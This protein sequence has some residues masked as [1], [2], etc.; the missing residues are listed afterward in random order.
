M[1]LLACE[2]RFQ[3]RPEIL[4]WIYMLLMLWVLEFRTKDGRRYL[5]LLPL[6]QVMWTN[7]EGLFG[8]GLGLMAF[9]VISDFFHSSKVDKAL[10][11]YASLAAASC[12]INPY[13][14][15]G[16]LLPFTY[17]ATL[18]A[19]SPFKQAIA[20]FQ[21]PWAMGN[22]FTTPALA[23]LSYKVYFFLLLFLLLA[24]FRKRQV[25]EFLVAGAFAY[26]SA[27]ALRNIPLFMLATLP[28]A[29]AAWRDLQWAWLQTFQARVLSRP[30]AAWVLVVAIV[31]LASRT[32][33]S[34]GY[35][36]EG[37]QDRFGLGLD[38]DT[39]PVRAGTFLVANNLEGRILNQMNTGGWLDWV[40]P[41]QVFIDGRTEVMGEDLFVESTA[42]LAP[43]GL[44]R[45]AAAYHPDILFFN[46]FAARQWL[47]DLDKM[48]DWRLVY[49]DEVVC[50]FLRKDYAPQV[51][52]L[53]PQRLLTERGIFTG[54]RER[55]G[56]PARASA[57]GMA[58]SGRGLLQ[59]RCSPERSADDGA[60]FSVPRRAAAVG[61]I[62]PG[63][64]QTEPRAFLR[65][66]LQR[67]PDVLPVS[68]ERKSQGLHGACARC[69]PWQC[70]CDEDPGKPLY[71]LSGNFCSTHPRIA[72]KTCLLFFSIIMK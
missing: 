64:H 35:I 41:G 24:T 53:D 50:V 15:R 67:G 40:R 56:S 38:T 21:S 14:F 11:L 17:L 45:I 71:A 9:S 16:V 42:S 18:D 48:A 62:L 61:G 60:L 25:R 36:S 20:E 2:V 31:A 4:S 58:T 55:A 28:I 22:R 7:S 19:A 34:A 33:T 63:M 68:P 27:T 46:P 44:A 54:Q 32:V 72:S 12:L 26:L 29:A 66:L 57:A 69:R 8:I 47:T 51:P 37:R 30:A 49:V 1:A 6:I 59:A 5:F 23:L 10:W 65:L 43:G 52:V 3:V 39:Q 70:E 13:G